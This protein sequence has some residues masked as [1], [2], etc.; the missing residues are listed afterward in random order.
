MK[1]IIIEVVKKIVFAICFIYAFDLI[2]SNLNLFIP[3][4]F[5]TVGVVSSLGISGLLA[6]IALYYV[7]L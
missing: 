1:K 6:L 2:A 3:I 4:N 5:I 7:L